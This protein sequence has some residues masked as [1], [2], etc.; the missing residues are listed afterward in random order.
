VRGHAELARPAEHPRVPH[1]SWQRELSDVTVGQVVEAL[2]AL[3]R[4]RAE[5]GDTVPD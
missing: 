2:S 4:I 1:G 3:I 5:T